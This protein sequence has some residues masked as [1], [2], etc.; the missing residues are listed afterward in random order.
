MSTN[1]NNNGNPCIYKG[2]I[3][4]LP[5]KLWTITQFD[6][7]RYL[8][9]TV[10]GMNIMADYVRW[11]GTEGNSYVRMRVCLPGKECISAAGIDSNGVIG[12]LLMNDG[13]P[14]LVRKDVLDKLKP[15]MIS[16]T[17]KN[18]RSMPDV[19]QQLANKGIHGA[20]LEEVIRYA[21]PAIVNENGGTWVCLYLRAE[22]ILEDMVKIALDD[23]TEG[24][25]QINR[26][27][28]G[29]P[30]REGHTDPI[31]WDLFV[32]GRVASGYQSIYNVTV[33]SLFNN[34]QA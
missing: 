3:D 9:N 31:S 20:N 18:V 15:F 21:T 27:N 1:N 30:N 14:Y 29:I 7:T 34:I 24:L 4:P 19:L 11:L 16:P 5:I 6:V 13:A 22:A 10:L 17:I 28:G 23:K 8:Q 2:G 25:M 12:E 26:V 32:N 33:E